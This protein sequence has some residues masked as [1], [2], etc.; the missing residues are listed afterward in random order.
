MSTP[1][2][3]KREPEGKL[4]VEIAEEKVREVEVDEGDDD[5]ETYATAPNAPPR[6]R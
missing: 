6:T 1:N 4:H 5:D 2:D 3:Q